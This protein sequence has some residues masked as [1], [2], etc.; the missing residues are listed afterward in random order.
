MLLLAQVGQLLFQPLDLVAE[1][2][3]LKAE[4]AARCQHLFGAAADGLKGLVPA[5]DGELVFALPCAAG[6]RMQQLKLQLARFEGVVDAVALVAQGLQALFEFAR[7]LAD[8]LAAAHRVELVGAE[9]Q[10]RRAAGG[11]PQAVARQARRQVGLDQLT[12]AR[13]D[14]RFDNAGDGGA[15][16]EDG[17]RVDRGRDR[18]QPAKENE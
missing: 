2:A 9:P 5:V 1:L 15:V 10:P 14:I 4:F 6:Q 17:D 18:D 7:P 8:A 13:I 12:G 3:P 11:N 16:R